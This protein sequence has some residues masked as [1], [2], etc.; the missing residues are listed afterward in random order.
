MQHRIPV[1]A[2]AR[3]KEIAEEELSCHAEMEPDLRPDNNHARAEWA[4][5]GPAR[6]PAVIAGVRNVVK[7]RHTNR[8]SPVTK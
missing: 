1:W 6:A 4:E 2:A 8:V 7:Q 5:T 3:K